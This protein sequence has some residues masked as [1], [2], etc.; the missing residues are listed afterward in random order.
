MVV[1]SFYVYLVWLFFGLKVLSFGGLKVCG[2][3][4]LFS[5][6]LSDLFCRLKWKQSNGRE[7]MVKTPDADQ[8]SYFNGARWRVA[9]G[10]F[11]DATN[12]SDKRT[13]SVCPVWLIDYGVPPHLRWTK[14]YRYERRYHR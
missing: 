13:G 11:V 8:T 6:V 14:K 4:F 5:L 12:Y 7:F 2:L 9:C 10:L 1:F 3:V